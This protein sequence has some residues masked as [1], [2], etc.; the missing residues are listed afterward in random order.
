MDWIPL[1][2]D[3]APKEVQSEPEIRRLR[4]VA[5]ESSGKGLAVG[6]DHDGGVGVEVGVFYP[7]QSCTKSFTFFLK[8]RS[9]SPAFDADAMQDF[10]VRRAPSRDYKP[11]TSVPSTFGC[12][13]IRIDDQ[14]STR[15]ADDAD[16]FV[17]GVVTSVLSC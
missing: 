6:V 3:R 2:L 8:G 7:F 4:S 15:V 13:S 16:R 12:W 10:G 14:I 5:F 1:D 9:D 17:I 11:C